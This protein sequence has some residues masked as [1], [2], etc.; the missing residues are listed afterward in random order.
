MRTCFKMKAH[1]YLFRISCLELYYPVIINDNICIVPNSDNM[2]DEIE[3]NLTYIDFNP[4]SFSFLLIQ[5]ENPIDR[6]ELENLAKKAIS[7]LIILILNPLYLEEFYHFKHEEGN[8]SLVE[9]SIKPFEEPDLKKKRNYL[10]GRLGV[11]SF[12]KIAGNLFKEISKNLISDSLYSIIM[13]YITSYKEP[14]IEISG[15]IAW[16]VLEHIAS[17]YWDKKNKKKLYI[18]RKE[19][20]EDYIDA[21]SQCADDFIDNIDEIKDVLIDHP[22]YKGN[23]KGL[24]KNSLSPEILKFS[25][26]K[27]R[28]YRMFEEEKIPYKPNKELIKDMYDIRIDR[29]HYGLNIA[30]IQLKRGKNPIDVIV[31]FRPFLYRKILEFLGFI[32]EFFFFDS[33]HLIKKEETVEV[34]NILEWEPDIPT[35]LDESKLIQKIKSLDDLLLKLIGT[36]LDAEVIDKCKHHKLRAI[37]SKNKGE[38]IITFFDPPLIFFSAFDEIPSNEQKYPED[39]IRYLRPIKCTFIYNNIRYEI[40]FYNKPIDYPKFNLKFSHPEIEKWIEEQTGKEREIKKDISKIHF[41]INKITMVE[42]NK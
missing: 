1:N 34:P 14:L 19:K 17:R 41:K 20:F 31:K 4:D 24:L 5:H 23:Y 15:T 37:L 22:N 27:F 18:I 9:A 32:D 11:Y 16:N 30:E 39:I 25:P 42:I 12:N 10:H 38:Y 8:L 21:L 7:M 6:E 29:F 36:D 13:E 28:I 33:G 2:R 3:S 26:V 40:E 35:K